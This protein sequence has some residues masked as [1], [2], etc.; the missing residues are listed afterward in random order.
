MSQDTMESPPKTR[1]KVLIVDDSFNLRKLLRTMLDKMCFD[2]TEAAGGLEA[3]EIAKE[4]LDT[5][6]LI[7]VDLLMPDM[8]GYDLIKTIRSMPGK[9]KPRVFVFTGVADS[10]EVLRLATLKIDAYL[11]KPLEI[12]AFSKRLDALFPPPPMPVQN[13]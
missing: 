1:G 2:V 4:K 8:H 13:P 12:A 10:Q 7:V 3:L 11:V 9:K 5:I 6:D